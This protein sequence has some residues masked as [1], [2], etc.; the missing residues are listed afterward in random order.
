M[1]IGNFRITDPVCR[2]LN[3]NFSNALLNSLISILSFMRLSIEYNKFYNKVCASEQSGN[4]AD[5]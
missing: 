3:Y 1:P 2:K 5:H 4:N